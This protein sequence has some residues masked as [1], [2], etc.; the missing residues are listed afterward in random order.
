MGLLAKCWTNTLKRLLLITAAALLSACASVGPQSERVSKI[1]PLESFNRGVFEFNQ[2]LDR[3]AVKPVA[4]AYRYVLP[5]FVRKGVTNFFQN[6]LDIYN[7]GHNLLQGKPIEAVS[8]IGRFAINS[9][10]GILGL[11]DVASDIGLEKHAEDFGQTLAVWGL[12]EGPYLV[13]PIF[14]PSSFRDAIGFGFDIRTDFILNSENIRNDDGLAITG[15][16]IVNRRANLI[17]A[18][19]LVDAAAFDAYSFIRDSY[20]QRRQ[21]QVYDG[22]PPPRKEE[23]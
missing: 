10:L 8:D 9:T 6:I 2:Q 21:N 13:L 14:G 23:D 11:I 19:E 1:D 5:D 20:L 18:G 12:P 17:D 22:N 16:R 15:L 7:A 4:Q 3:Y